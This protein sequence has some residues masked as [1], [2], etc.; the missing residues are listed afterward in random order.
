MLSQTDGTIKSQL[1]FL[2]TTNRGADNIDSAL[3]R[4]GRAFDVLELRALH[5]EEAKSIWVEYGLKEKSFDGM[6]G[7]GKVTQAEL[8]SE[9]YRAIKLNNHKR[10]EYLKEPEISV[11]EKLKGK[12]K[13]RKISL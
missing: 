5:N 6:F 10:E 8:G 2:I 4:R 3:L 9:I 7:D 1:K 11:L 13:K 12:S